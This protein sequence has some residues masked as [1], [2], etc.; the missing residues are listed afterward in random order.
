MRNLSC[1]VDAED[2]ERDPRQKARM[3]AELAALADADSPFIDLSNAPQLP[4][5]AWQQPIHGLEAW[6]QAARKQ[7]A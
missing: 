2:L 5:T 1:V 4:A 3:D 6:L 7:N